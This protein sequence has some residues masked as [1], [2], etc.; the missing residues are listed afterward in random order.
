MKP[1]ILVIDDEKSLRFTFQ[2]FLS[3]EGY[4]VDTAADY[5]EALLRIGQE[6]YDV[7]FSDILLGDKTGIDVL[8]AIKEQ[9][10]LCPVIMVTGY[11]N[12]ETASEALRLG[13]FDYIS[14]PVVKKDLLQVARAAIKYRHVAEENERNRINLEAVFSSVG[15]GLIIVD[16]Q[17]ELQRANEAA[18]RIFQLDEEVLGQPYR[19]ALSN[20]SVRSCDLLQSTLETGRQGQLERIECDHSPNSRQVLTLLTSP[21]VNAVGEA[22]GAVLVTRDET[23]IDKL[24][25]SLRK[26]HNFHKMVGASNKMQ[27]LYCLL[28]DLADVPSTVLITGES[29]TG[30]ELVA[31]AL[32]K[33]GVRHNKPLVK[34]NCAALSDTLL[35]SELFGHVRG[36]FTG[37]VKDRIGR[38]QKAEGGTIFLDEIGDISHKVQLR[39]LRVLQEREIE[40]I[41]ESMPT[42]V[43]IRIVAATNR[44]L[45]E[46]VRQGSFREDLYYRLKVITIPLPP[47]RERKDDIPLLVEHMIDKLNGTMGKEVTGISQEVAE[48]FQEY[49]WPGNIRELEHVM[50]YAFVRCRQPVVALGHLPEDLL[51]TKDQNSDASPQVVEEDEVQSICKALEKTAWNKAKAARLL[52]IDRKT[53]YRKLAKYEIDA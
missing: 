30:K 10:P 31:E 27:E 4:E 33:S 40:R 41:G 15:D 24:E 20:C 34:V 44:N 22:I 26:R 23:R 9:I 6:C 36:S 16:Q 7:V 39:L 3:D 53:L 1:K 18:Q 21:L 19:E 45:A 29:G 35:E 13:A 37:A 51:A 49:N 11:P 38:F 42:K 48:F 46:M 17:G 32:H 47:L 43:D 8:R 5:Q 52:G 2:R 50:E 12:I 28:D 14:K 25:R